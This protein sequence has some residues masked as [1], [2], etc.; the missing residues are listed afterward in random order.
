MLHGPGN[1]PRANEDGLE[2]AD[3]FLRLVIRH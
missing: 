3:D 2:E 1:P